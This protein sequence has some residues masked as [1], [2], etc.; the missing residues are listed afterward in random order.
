M[1]KAA[2][3]FYTKKDMANLIHRSING[4]NRLIDRDKTRKDKVLPPHTKVG[5]TL[6]WKQNVVSDWFESIEEEASLY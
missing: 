1:Q 5:K 2:P 6:L 3:E 4:L